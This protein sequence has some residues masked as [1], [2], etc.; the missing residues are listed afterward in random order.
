MNL[1]TKTLAIP[2]TQLKVFILIVFS[3]V[4]L[5]QNQYFAQAKDT[6][7]KPA[8]IKFTKF[9]MSK[10]HCQNAKDIFPVSRWQSLLDQIIDSNG[11]L[12]YPR[13]QSAPLSE[14]F[15][16]LV[17]DIYQT[18][19]DIHT[20][21]CSQLAFWLNAYNALTIKQ[22]L[23]YPNLESVAT[24][25]KD[26]PRYAFFKQKQHPLTQEFIHDQL[27]SLDDIEHRLIRARFAEPRI[28]F[29]LNCA[30]QSCPPLSRQA[31]FANDLVQQLEQVTKNFINHPKYNRFT[32]RT[33]SVSKIFSWYKEDFIIHQRLSVT[34]HQK[35]ITTSDQAL[36]S[37]I[38]QYLDNK[39][40]KAQARPI[41]PSPQ[42]PKEL[43]TRAITIEFL[44][45]DWS[46]NGK[47]PK[48]LN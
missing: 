18:K 31:F 11:Q 15:Q 4:N 8:Q 40:L 39:T 2:K 22:V 36:K 47:R 24:A 26:A 1:G 12:D 3:W 45:Y 9:Q 37:Y 23:A 17:H 29:A 6:Q 27:L 13:L 43:S 16:A 42:K 30:S 34:G 46:L 48:S 10:L 41:S 14:Q 32:D 21:A 5:S 44:N 25:V 33:W 19:V 7:V 38:E 28:H 20:S 35:E